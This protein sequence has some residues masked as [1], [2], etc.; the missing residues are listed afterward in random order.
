M[1]R[2]FGVTC[3]ALLALLCA[4]G[5]PPKWERTSANAPVDPGSVEYLRMKRR[6]EA[7]SARCEQEVKLARIADTDLRSAAFRDCLQKRG[8]REIAGE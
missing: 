6:L 5:T 3:L 4:C 2:S 1:T 7:D 8:W